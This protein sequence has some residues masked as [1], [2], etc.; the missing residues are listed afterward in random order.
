MTQKEPAAVGSRESSVG[1]GEERRDHAPHLVRLVVGGPLSVGA[2]LD[3]GQGCVGIDEGADVGDEAV[4]VG[5]DDD[6]GA[7]DD[8]G[9]GLHE[10]VGKEP[11]EITVRE[12]VFLLRVGWEIAS[13]RGRRSAPPVATQAGQGLI[14]AVAELFDGSG[15]TTSLGGVSVALTVAPPE[16]TATNRSSAVEVSAPS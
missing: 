4:G 8:V 15:S 2:R 12:H 6:V 3:L 11:P 13:F 14:T 10:V 9:R 7:V 16:M 1:K 5:A